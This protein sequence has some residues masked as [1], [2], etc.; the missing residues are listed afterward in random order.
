MY[1]IMAIAFPFVI[2]IERSVILRII[3]YC[4]DKICHL[5]KSIHIQIFSFVL[6]HLIKYFFQSLL[7]IENS[8]FIHVIPKSI[9]SL[10]YQNSIFISKPSSCFII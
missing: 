7:R 1:L 5:K 2:V 8:R 10:I 4:T 9:N 6:F 3:G